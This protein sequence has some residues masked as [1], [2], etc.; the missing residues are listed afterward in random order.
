MPYWVQKTQVTNYLGAF[1]CNHLGLQA[2]LGPL[3][4]SPGLSPYKPM[5]CPSPASQIRLV[6]VR[7]MKQDGQHIPDTGTLLH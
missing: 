7:E 6:Q 5:V 4:H 3:R 1:H 2:E